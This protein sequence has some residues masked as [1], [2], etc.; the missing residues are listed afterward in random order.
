MCTIVLPSALIRSVLTVR[1][2]AGA[3]FPSRLRVVL[4]TLLP[5]TVYLPSDTWTR[6]LP[7]WTDR[8]SMRKVLSDF[9]TNVNFIALIAS[10]ADL[11]IAFCCGSVGSFTFDMSN[12]YAPIHVPTGLDATAAATA[13]TIVATNNTTRFDMPQYISTHSKES[14]LSALSELGSFGLK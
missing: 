9:R 1:S 14:N 8:I 6:C 13:N 12:L 4:T 11:A 7:A 3:A 10:M 2:F 5:V